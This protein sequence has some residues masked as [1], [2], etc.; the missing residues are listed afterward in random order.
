[1]ALNGAQAD[2]PHEPCFT[3]LAMLS[4]SFFGIGERKNP[5]PPL[6]ET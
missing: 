1:M 6:R 5:R 3:D 4:L 2:G